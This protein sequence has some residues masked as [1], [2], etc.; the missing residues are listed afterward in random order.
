V[1]RLDGRDWGGN[2]DNSSKLALKTMAQ[3]KIAIP[4]ASLW[5]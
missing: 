3:A 5:P 4:F 2:R 1:P